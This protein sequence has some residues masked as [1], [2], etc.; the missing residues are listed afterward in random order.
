MR[1]HIFLFLGGLMQMIGSAASNDFDLPG[2]LLNALLEHFRDMKNFFCPYC[3]EYC[4]TGSR[5]QLPPGSGPL[6][7]QHPRLPFE[8]WDPLSL[9]DFPM[10]ANLETCTATCDIRLGFYLNGQGYRW[11]NAMRDTTEIVQ[12]DVSIE[13]WFERYIGSIA[14]GFLLEEGGCRKD[15]GGGGGGDR[16]EDPEGS[17]KHWTG[18]LTD[19][20]SEFLRKRRQ[21]QETAAPDQEKEPVPAGKMRSNQNHLHAHGSPCERVWSKLTEPDLGRTGRTTSLDRSRPF[22]SQGAAFA[23]PESAPG[24]VPEVIPLL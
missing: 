20:W 18:D 15:H 2:Q 19:Q 23:P 22:R 9:H 13:S 12:W 5:P 7:R 17:G 8:H 21:D 3:I 6:A 14:F 11:V 1:L 16:P 10:P 4:L 24:V